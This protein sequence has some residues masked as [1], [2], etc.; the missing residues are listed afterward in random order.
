MVMCNPGLCK[1]GHGC[2]D[3]GAPLMETAM[4]LLDDVLNCP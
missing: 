4:E 3:I 2:W 1:I